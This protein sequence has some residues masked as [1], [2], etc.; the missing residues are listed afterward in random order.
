[1]SL[2][3]GAG[4][5]TD[6]F[7]IVDGF[8]ATLDEGGARRD[9]SASGQGGLTLDLSL[10]RA[11]TGLSMT[12]SGPTGS[13][14]LS[15]TLSA[16]TPEAALDAINAAT[17]QTGVTARLGSDGH[18][19]MLEGGAIS[20][21][22][23]RSNPQ[24]TDVVATATPLDLAGQ[25]GEAI[26]LVSA[27]QSPGDQIGHLAAASNHIA[28]TLAQVGVLGDVAGRQQ[29]A[30]DDRQVT[31]DSAIAGLEDLDLA[32]AITRLQKLMLTRDTAQQSF[33]KIGQRSLF[34][35]LR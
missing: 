7:S 22:D 19:L 10:T 29:Q 13:A 2:P 17:G 25:S 21:S 24:R 32:D 15:M 8:L 23:M 4:G 9:T 12:V 6:V 26:P 3:D 27:G 20:V 31:M 11:P 33:V 34:D 18:T 35:Y 1:M 5:T 14:D 16:D 28:D 30:L